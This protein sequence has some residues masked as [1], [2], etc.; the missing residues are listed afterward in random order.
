MSRNGV[1]YAS[2]YDTVRTHV[3]RMVEGERMKCTVEMEGAMPKSVSITSMTLD[4]SRQCAA[5]VVAGDVGA[6][7]FDVW[8]TGQRC[9]E[10]VI[11]A[12]TTLSDG[13]CRVHRIWVRVQ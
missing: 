12:R 10:G 11:F 8:M 13:V 6:R 3:L 7:R 1:F 2:A 4:T 5:D 9:G